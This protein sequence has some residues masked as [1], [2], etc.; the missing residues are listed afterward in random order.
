MDKAKKQKLKKLLKKKKALKKQPKEDTEIDE[1][2]LRVKYDVTF[3][4]QKKKDKKIKVDARFKSMFKDKKFGTGKTKVDRYGRRV[5]TDSKG[6][7]SDLKKYYYEDNSQG[8]S[9]SENEQEKVGKKSKKSKKKNLKKKEK[10]D[11]DEKMPFHWSEESSSSEDFS[12]DLNQLLGDDVQEEYDFLSDQ[13]D[14]VELREMSS[15]RLA[16]MNYDWARIKPS[17]VYLTMS[18]FLPP[19]GEV[20]KVELYLSDFGKEMKE[21]EAVEGPLAIMENA[22]EDG[23]DLQDKSI[24]KFEL[25]RLKYYYSVIYFD[26]AK[27]ADFVY[28]NVNNMEL[29]STGVK[30]D[31]RAVPDEMEFPRKPEETCT[32]KPSKVSDLNFVIKARQHTNVEITWEKPEKGNKNAFLFEMDDNDLDKVDFRDILASDDDMPDEAE[33]EDEEEVNMMEVRRKLLGRGNRDVFADFDKSK[34]KQDIEV[35]FM[36]AFEDEESDSDDSE[37]KEKIQFSRNFRQDREDDHVEEEEQEADYFEE[38]Q[39]DMD[40]EQPKKSKKETKREKFRKKLKEKRRDKVEAMRKKRE[41]VNQRRRKVNQRADL[42]LL[43]KREKAE[44]GEFQVDL[45]DDRFKRMFQDRD[46]AVDPTNPL[47]DR[48]K[49][50]GVIKAKDKRKKMKT[51]NFE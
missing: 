47:Y 12:Q 24:R 25:D 49:M 17:D 33:Q 15:T 20:I 16:M 50:K 48:K 39:Q 13:E 10:K 29:Q 35:N 43:S 18:S 8:S 30:I 41:A 21:K 5:D 26:S 9:S 38:E 34:G 42:E 22:E 28:N 40:E 37:D 3:Q 7:N 4:K 19:G 45:E 2:F 32:E 27:S 51:K 36:A 23:D 14:Q 44:G 1:R 31:L 46:M 11:K 6:E